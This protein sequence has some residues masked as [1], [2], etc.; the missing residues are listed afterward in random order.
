MDNKEDYFND[1]V[2]RIQRDN[3]GKDK[4]DE[5]FSDV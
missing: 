1:L 5:A 4:S 2:K 3:S